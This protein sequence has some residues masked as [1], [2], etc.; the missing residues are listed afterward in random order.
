MEQEFVLAATMRPTHH[1]IQMQFMK[2]SIS[3]FGWI[4]QF[5]ASLNLQTVGFYRCS[6]L[7]ALNVLLLYSCRGRM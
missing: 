3:W 2:H 5:V 1:V 4:G 6:W 7:V